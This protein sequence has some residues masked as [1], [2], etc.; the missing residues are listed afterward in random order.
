MHS[1][2]Y[3]QAPIK[4]VHNQLCCIVLDIYLWCMCKMCTLFPSCNSI[5]FN[6]IKYMVHRCRLHLHL[7]V[8]F[9][10]L[11]L[12]HFHNIHH[13]SFNF[14]YHSIIVTNV[15]L[16]WFQECVVIHSNWPIWLV[17]L[18]NVLCT[19]IHI[20]IHT[21]IWCHRVEIVRY[22]IEL[23]VEWDDRTI[24]KFKTPIPSK[25]LLNF[26]YI[27]CVWYIFHNHMCKFQEIDRSTY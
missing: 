9:F 15:R 13:L 27:D 4:C 16:E 8:V 7:D 20:N 26:G 5:V 14:P 25:V 23:S 10:F 3:V 24:E 18:T 2:L 6:E 1:K 12:Y 21:E 17:M 11:S 19:H 22:S